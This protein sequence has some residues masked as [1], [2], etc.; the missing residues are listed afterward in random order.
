[1]ESKDD[2][3][4]DKEVKGDETAKAE[5][6]AEDDPKPEIKEKN[7]DKESASM[8]ELA[9]VKKPDH[10]RSVLEKAGIIDD[11]ELL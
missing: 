7:K 10:E 9:A 3:S 8:L 6:K 1:M 11:D 4:K 2:S 5:K